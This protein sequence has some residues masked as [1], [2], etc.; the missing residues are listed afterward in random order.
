MSVRRHTPALQ[1]ST[2]S[3]SP[4]A[5]NASAPFFV[6]AHVDR[7]SSSGRSCADAPAAPNAARSFAT[8][9]SAEAWLRAVTVTRAPFSANTRAVSKP[10]PPPAP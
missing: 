4:V 8:A 3:D 7:S 2:S 5:R 10:S 9:V 6:E 1:M